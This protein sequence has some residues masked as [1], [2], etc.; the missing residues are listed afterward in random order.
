MFA[1]DTTIAKVKEKLLHD[2]KILTKW[3]HENFMALNAG[4]CHYMCKG[5]EN[6]ENDDF[7]FNG[8]KLENSN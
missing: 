6:I 1:I 4:K 5:S 2:F 7:I 3:F 8:M